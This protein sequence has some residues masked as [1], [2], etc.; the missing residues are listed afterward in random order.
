MHGGLE[1]VTE[2]VTVAF[3]TVRG[4]EALAVWLTAVAKIV[5]VAVRGVEALAVRLP[6]VATVVLAAV[7]GV[8]ELLDSLTP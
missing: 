1:V 2:G 6:A 7:L 8:G 3:V 4:A 5:L